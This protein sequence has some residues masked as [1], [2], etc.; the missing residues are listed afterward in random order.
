MTP[1]ITVAYL[2]VL[3]CALFVLIRWPRLRLQGEEPVGLFTLIALLFTAGLDM[4]LVM[5]PLAEFP[6]YEED[7][8]FG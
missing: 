5:L 7:P 2:S 6:I 8:A 4:G 3:A 1:I